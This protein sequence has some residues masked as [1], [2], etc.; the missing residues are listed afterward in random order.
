MKKILA[1]LAVCFMSLWGATAY[2]ADMSML[3]TTGTITAVEDDKAVIKANA[4]DKDVALYIGKAPYFIDKESGNR[5]TVD[6]VKAGTQVTAFYGPR[7][8]RSIPPIGV[9]SMMVLGKGDEKLAYVRVSRA[10][11]AD[12]KSIILYYDEAAVRITEKALPNCT[13]V[14]LGDQLLV[15]FNPG[16]TVQEG[17]KDEA[18]ERALLLNR[19]L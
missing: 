1:L 18:V 10:V 9:A 4:P 17:T 7:L 8:T 3:Q 13:A 5:L 2:A 16:Y 12:N 19:S 11:P 14:R 15:W 6:A